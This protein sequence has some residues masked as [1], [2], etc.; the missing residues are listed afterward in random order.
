MRGRM[1]DLIEG[2]ISKLTSAERKLLDDLK[3]GAE[4]Y[5]D[6]EF[7]TEVTRAPKRKGGDTREQDQIQLPPNKKQRTLADCWVAAKQEAGLN[8][9]AGTGTED[10]RGEERR[11]PEEEM[12]AGAPLQEEMMTS[13]VDNQARDTGGEARSCNLEGEKATRAPPEVEKEIQD[14]P[15]D[16][17]VDVQHHDDDI[18]GDQLLIGGTGGE[19]RSNPEEEKEAG[20]P[21]EVVKEEPKHIGV[22]KVKTLDQFFNRLDKTDKDSPK[23]TPKTKAGSIKK[24]EKRKPAKLDNK[25]VKSMQKNLSNFLNREREKTENTQ[26]FEVRSPKGAPPWPP[27]NHS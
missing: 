8:K 26:A 20:V 4:I 22:S 19:T 10:S 21:P 16:A 15:G 3:A 24:R 17:P 2:N 14:A 23:K 25:T 11:Y 7:W 12:E 1:V 27:K 18:P 6:T 9:T 5:S 13:K